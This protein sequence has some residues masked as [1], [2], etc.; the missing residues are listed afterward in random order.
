[1]SDT[2]QKLWD[3]LIEL[4]ATVGLRILLAIA[5]LVVGLLLIKYIV[6]AIVKSKGF[7]KIDKTV[8][9]FTKSALSITLKILLIVSVIGILG[10]PL[11]SIIAVL[12]SA[13]LAIGLALQG[14]LSNFAGGIMI[15]IFRPFR[16]GDFIDNGTHMGT[17]DSI[18]IFYTK[19]LTIDNKLIT[20]PNSTMTSASVTNFSAKEKRR[21][22]FKFTA[23]YTNDVDKV[24]NILLE[25]ANNHPMVNQ[26]PPVMAKLF[27]HGDNSLEYILRAWVDA[28]NYWDVYFD[29]TEQ[30]K[31]E[32]DKQGIEIP[33]PQ[34]DVHIKEKQIKER[35]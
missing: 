11:T 1:M 12:A 9:I 24:N 10:V 15:L 33:Y 29:I 20:I 16:V 6:K 14:A 25:I 19:L 7:N 30:V 26:D 27:A 3:T 18:T 17:V 35:E 34:M 21:V 31:K 22:D 4:S 28:P 23:S 32:F 8:Q 2:L 13:G 5:V